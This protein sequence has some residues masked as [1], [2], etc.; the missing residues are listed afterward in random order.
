[1]ELP[2]NLREVVEEKK[3]QE[4]VKILFVVPKPLLSSTGTDSSQ[5]ADID[6]V[7]LAYCMN[8]TVS[9]ETASWQPEVELLA[10]EQTNAA[11]GWNH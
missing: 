4:N 6:K 1:M 3:K 2:E 9:F 5:E 7:A 10:T 8:P 11:P